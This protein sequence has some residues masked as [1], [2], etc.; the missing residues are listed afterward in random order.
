[1]GGGAVTC[2]S[3]LNGLE[4]VH[5]NVVLLAGPDWR[6]P[7]SVLTQIGSHDADE[8]FMSLTVSISTSMYSTSRDARAYAFLLDGHPDGGCL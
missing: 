4:R 6:V 2:K 7:E 1:M 3:D 8:Y 5:G